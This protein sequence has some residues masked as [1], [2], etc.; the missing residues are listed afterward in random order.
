MTIHLNLY[1]TS[2]CHLCELAEALVIEAEHQHD[3]QYETI[4]IADDPTLYAL[5]EIRIPILKRLDNHAEISW[6]FSIENLRQFLE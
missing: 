3:I 5:Y 6:P 2:N 1:S 4:E